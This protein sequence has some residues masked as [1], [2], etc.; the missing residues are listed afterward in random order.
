M[1]YVA[2]LIGLIQLD[3]FHWSAFLSLFLILFL[4][5]GLEHVPFFPMS[6]ASSLPTSERFQLAL[7]SSS[8]T[9]PPPPPG[10][11]LATHTVPRGTIRCSKVPLQCWLVARVGTGGL[12]CTSRWPRRNWHREPFRFEGVIGKVVSDGTVHYFPVLLRQM[13]PDVHLPVIHSFISL[14]MPNEAQ[15][16]TYHRH[17]MC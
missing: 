16:A 15:K 10:T 4:F 12:R 8:S 5:L 7:D 17:Y 1:L 11:V 2:P 6:S 9:C 13:V 3:E 14:A